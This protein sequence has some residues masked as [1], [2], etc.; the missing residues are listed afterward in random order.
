[1]KN[2][3][4]LIV[5]FGRLPSP[6]VKRFNH[7]LYLLLWPDIFIKTLRFF[8]SIGNYLT[9]E[10]LSGLAYLR[11]WFVSNRLA[12]CFPSTFSMLRTLTSRFVWICVSTKELIDIDFL[13]LQRD[14]NK[15]ML[16]LKNFHNK[17]PWFVN[18]HSLKNT[19]VH[20][21]RLLAH[22]III[23]SLEVILL[24][25]TVSKTW[26]K[27][28]IL[29]IK[30]ARNHYM[31]TL[32]ERIVF[33]HLPT[34]CSSLLNTRSNLDGWKPSRKRVGKWTCWYKYRS[35]VT[36]KN[37]TVWLFR[38]T[39][40]AFFPWFWP[41]PFKVKKYMF[42]CVLTRRTQLWQQ[43]ADIFLSAKVIKIARVTSILTRVKKI[44]IISKVLIE[45]FR[46]PPTASF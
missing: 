29:I 19:P 34:M 42:R 27:T 40:R 7:C 39:D 20:T 38:A 25:T 4:S 41:W 2:L 32:P 5:I 28:H 12:T 11:R 10:C 1:M 26:F 3:S 31:M 16:L 23:P 37:R 33:N 44:F 24:A 17:I 6:I 45:S 22:V 46:T 36:S 18:V 30:I 8:P 15:L 43:H 13:A 35:W 9:F 14:T 21:Y